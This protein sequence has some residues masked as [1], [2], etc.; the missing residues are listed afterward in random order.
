MG[1]APAL[2]VTS[3]EERAGVVVAG[4]HREGAVG[5]E[6][7]AIVGRKH[8]LSSDAHGVSFTS[9]IVAP[10]RVL[11]YLTDV[12]P[13]LIDETVQTLSAVLRNGALF[14][15]PAIA[16]DQPITG[17]VVLALGSDREVT[18]SAEARA[19]ESHE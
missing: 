1:A 6:L 17:A 8:T 9:D 4:R 13:V 5:E 11:R 16:A 19:E 3:L 10:L 14:P 18:I 2:H 15:A 12:D 7:A